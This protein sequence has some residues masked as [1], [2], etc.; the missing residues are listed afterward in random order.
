MQEDSR[1]FITG[2]VLEPG[3]RC[4]V[5]PMGSKGPGTVRTL[6]SALLPPRSSCLSRRP[7]TAAAMA[8]AMV[9]GDGM[10]GGGGG[11]AVDSPRLQSHAGAVTTALMGN[12]MAG[13]AGVMIVSTAADYLS[14][15]HP[16]Q[17]GSMP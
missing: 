12:E 17:L 6:T 8:A 16:M 3:A 10:I 11:A 2:R 15:H 1:P 13:A 5:Q 4:I 9:G 7:S 14:G